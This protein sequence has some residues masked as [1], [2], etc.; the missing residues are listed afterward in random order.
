MTRTGDETLSGPSVAQRVFLA[1]LFLLVVTVPVVAMLIR[2]VSGTVPTRLVFVP[3]PPI[4]QSVDLFPRVSEAGFDVTRWLWGVLAD[5]LGVV[6]AVVYYLVLFTALL[7][8]GLAVGGGI[9]IA[10]PREMARTIRRALGLRIVRM[11][12]GGY[13]AIGLTIL[14]PATVRLVLEL[15]LTAALW[16]VVLVALAVLWRHIESADHVLSRIA[17]WYPLT[18]ALVVLPSVVVGIVSPSARPLFLRVSAIMASP[19]LES[20]LVGGLPAVFFVDDFIPTA[21]AYGGFW[22][23]VVLVMGW[24]VGVVTEVWAWLPGRL[25]SLGASVWGRVR[26]LGRGLL[27]R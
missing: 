23:G 21:V 14:F 22:V 7:G 25:V 12:L 6:F 8:T 20:G 11:L 9:G 19:I 10:D 26:R 15:V 1:G 16:L 18:V 4:E 2:A 24:F 5:F 13:T 27:D 17:L 3:L